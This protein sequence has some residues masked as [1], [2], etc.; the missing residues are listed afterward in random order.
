MAEEG[1]L[2]NAVSCIGEGIILTDEQGYII[3]I[4]S[5]AENLTGWRSREAIDRH[6][7]EVFRLVD[8]LTR[9]RLKSPIKE[10]LDNVGAFGLSNYSALVKK[11]GRIIFVSAN[12]SSICNTYNEIEGAA[13]V[14]RDIDRIKHMEEDIRREKNNLKNVLEA[15]PQAIL[16]VDKDEVIRWENDPFCKLFHITAPYINGSRF[17][18]VT[19]C[20]DSYESGCG[21]GKNCCNCGIRKALKEA[22]SGENQDKTIIIRHS[23]AGMNKI[24]NYWLRIKF[25][26]MVNLQEND[27]L[28]VIDDITEQKE[29][30]GYLQKSREEAEA[31]NRA[32][33]E[34][35]ANMTHELRTPLNGIIGMSNLLLSSNL[36]GEQ[37]ENMQMIKTCASGLLQMINNLLDAAIIDAGKLDIINYGFDFRALLEET[38]LMFSDLAGNKNLSFEYNIAP[39]IP[40]VLKGDPNRLRQIINNLISNAVK[41]TNNGGIRFDVE[42]LSLTKH[43][44]EIKFSV[45]D[46]G[47]GISDENINRLFQK[48]SQVDGSKTRVYGG[49]GL[50][51]ALCKQLIEIMNGDIGVKSKKD[52][53]STFYFTLSFELDSKKSIMGIDE[54]NLGEFLI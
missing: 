29:Y 30:E 50:G 34:F 46:T 31:A 44:A 13:V 17:G 10:A 32:K 14:F 19:N 47:I 37:T 28:M 41:F 11:D 2:K 42:L 27:I 9:E 15:L 1:L 39:E 25:I 35:L 33:S 4:N 38:I 16:V 48:F 5:A 7:D 3:F 36:S 53:G 21:E 6:F 8:Y 26:P 45:S 54:I 18:D 52:L 23:V 40:T 20:L 24:D 49:T 22:F 12:C 43:V 51:L